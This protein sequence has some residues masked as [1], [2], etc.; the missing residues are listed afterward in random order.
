MNYEREFL[1]QPPLDKQP[2][3][4]Y[5]DLKCQYT[6]VTFSDATVEAYNQYTRDFNRTNWRATQ[7]FLLDQRHKFIHGLMYQNLE[8]L[9]LGP[10]VQ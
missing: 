2:L 8:K 10:S 3:A 1:G 9:Q 7:E 4:Q 6:G 5:G